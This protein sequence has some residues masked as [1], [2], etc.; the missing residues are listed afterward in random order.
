LNGKIEKKAVKG[1]ITD[2]GWK[3]SQK[4]SDIH[5]NYHK[6][7]NIHGYEIINGKK[8]GKTILYK[9]SK[10]EGYVHT[11]PKTGKSGKWW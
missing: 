9:G 2:S 10:P 1:N 3:A 6:L 4:A 11:D 8:T 5:M 7:I